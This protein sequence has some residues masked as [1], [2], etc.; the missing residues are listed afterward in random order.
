MKISILTIFCYLLVLNITIAQR[1]GDAPAPGGETNKKKVQ[2]VKVQA[3]G[4]VSY[5]GNL[6][7][8]QSLSDLRWA[9]NSSVACFPAT[10]NQKFTGNHVFYSTT[11]PK[12]S[13]MF[14]KVIPKDKSTLRDN[15]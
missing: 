1:G 13:E 6:S 5:E 2:T 14:I 12:R 7:E 8:G 3:N 11:I 4:T 15:F 10:Q 9:A